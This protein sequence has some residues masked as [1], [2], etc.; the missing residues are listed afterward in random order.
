MTTPVKYDGKI[1]P[2]DFATIKLEQAFNDKSI[3]KRTVPMFSGEAGPE[4]GIEAMYHVKEAYEHACKAL[5]WNTSEEKF[6]N[7]NEVVYSLALY[8]WTNTIELAFSNPGP[9]IW[10]K[11]WKLMAVRFSTGGKHSKDQLLEYLKSDACRKQIKTSV[12]EHIARI[13][14]MIHIADQLE[15]DENRP[16]TTT[17]TKSI[18]IKSMPS[19]WRN[20]LKSSNAAYMD[21]DINDLQ[22]YFNLQ[23]EISDNSNGRDVTKNHRATANGKK[24]S[25]FSKGK[26]NEDYEPSQQCRKHPQHKHTWAQ[27]FQNPK[28]ESFKGN[29]KAKNNNWKSSNTNW[30]SGNSKSNTDSKKQ[31]ARN[32]DS[33]VS[34]ATKSSTVAERNVGAAGTN[35]SE[36][37]SFWE[38]IQSEL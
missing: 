23:K 34:G 38:H 12:N 30:K 15:G 17:Q 1:K 7:F 16:V 29:K 22:D 35:R 13:L 36:A 20:N 32:A 26:A 33:D 18:I 14:R 9:D 19:S 10:E 27:C 24:G 21:M 5:A 11:A 28:G 8:Y 4:G 37:E 2:K 31:E 25:K 3:V 6:N